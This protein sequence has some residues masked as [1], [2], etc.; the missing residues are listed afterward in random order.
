MAEGAEGKTG[1]NGAA[2]YLRTAS[3]QFRDGENRGRQGGCP[4]GLQR[5]RAE[6]GS[7]CEGDGIYP[8]GMYAGDGA[9]GK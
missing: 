3:W 9:Y 2:Q 1:G 8:C 6:A 5:N 4:A 7:L